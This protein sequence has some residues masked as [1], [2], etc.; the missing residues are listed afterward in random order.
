M[1]IIAGTWR[2]RRIT[3][4]PGRHVRPTGDRVREAWMSAMGG[5]FDGLVVW[6]L[7]AGSGALGL[8]CLSRGA[9]RC[10][11][12]ERAPAAT[13]VIHANLAAL[14]G[15]AGARVVQADALRWIASDPPPPPADLALADPPYGSGAARAL[16]EHFA[17]APFAR[18][19]WVEHRIDDDV[20]EL[21]GLRRRR[22]GETTLSTLAAPESSA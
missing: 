2:G 14:G 16:L 1:R 5:R 21:P 9:A 3:A 20:P 19:L 10:I 12:V 15:H 6:D 18:E 11:F 8:E 22:Y 7:F 17:A 4:P 13:R